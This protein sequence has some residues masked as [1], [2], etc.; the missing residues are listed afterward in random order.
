MAV[1]LLK[2]IKLDSKWKLFPVAY[3]NGKPRWSYIVRNGVEEHHPEGNYHLD[4]RDH[5]GRRHRPSVGKVP[6]AVLEA[7]HRKEAELAAVVLAV[8]AG[9]AS[10]LQI[11]SEDAKPDDKH[12]SIRQAATQYLRDVSILKSKGTY[13][14][15]NEVIGKFLRVVDC[16][17]VEDVTRRDLMNFMAV[18]HQEG[19]GGR[20]IEHKT[21]IVLTW[22]KTFGKSK[23][24]LRQDWPEYVNAEKRPYDL[25]DLARFF[26]ACDP[27]EWILF[28]FFLHTGFR[29]QE[30]RVSEYG[31]I[32]FKEGIVRVREKPQY[33][34]KP[35]G[36]EIRDVPIPDGLLKA[37]AERKKT[38]KAKLL[39][40]SPAHWKTPKSLPGGK[41]DDKFL[42]RCKEIALRAGLNCGEC[43]SDREE[44]C[45]VEPCCRDWTL[46]RWRHT[47]GTMHLRAGVDIQTVS[48]WMG[49]QDIR[50]TSE[51]L[52]AIRAAE[53]RP[54]VNHGALATLLTKKG[55]KK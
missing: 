51:Y 42:T 44:S 24:L 33:G 55:K 3:R 45:A 21:V 35:K 16:H 10:G 27:E 14:K 4:Y 2:N 28:E 1:S 47:F 46:H 50:T 52:K 9:K 19:N 31:D 13:R 7:L 34:F 49:H 8:A 5:W 54:K 32:D 40:P 25:D 53:A 48:T 38:A 23:L 12:H 29:D 11:I 41:P 37:L 6:G 15:Y 39:F 30:V 20:T 43:E 36:K 22:L 26:S 18:L 17:Y